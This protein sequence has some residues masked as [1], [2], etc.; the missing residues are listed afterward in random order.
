MVYE[1]LMAVLGSV[2]DIVSAV[3]AA[4]SGHTFT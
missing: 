4:C 3:S 1:R 2:N